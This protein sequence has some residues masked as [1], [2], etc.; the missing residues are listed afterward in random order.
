[1]L[2]NWNIPSLEASLISANDVIR[3]IGQ[4]AMVNTISL[5]TLL[6]NENV[7]EGSDYGSKENLNPA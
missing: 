1:M 2:W 7:F 6:S 4:D 5:G 3:A